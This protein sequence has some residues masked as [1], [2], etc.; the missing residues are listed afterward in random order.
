[1]R[2]GLRQGAGG[3]A[4]TLAVVMGQAFVPA[5]ATLKTVMGVSGIFN[6]AFWLWPAP[7]VAA[8]ALAAKSLF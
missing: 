1:M 3:L 8:A 2:L 5:S 7:L 6:V 4:L